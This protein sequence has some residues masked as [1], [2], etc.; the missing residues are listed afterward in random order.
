MSDSL[1]DLVTSRV[2][3][4]TDDQL[5]AIVLLMREAWRE[6]NASAF[7]EVSTALSTDYG[8][9]TMYLATEVEAKREETLSLARTLLDRAFERAMA[10]E[11]IAMS[12]EQAALKIGLSKRKLQDLVDQ[13]RLQVRRIDRR[14]LVTPDALREMLAD[15]D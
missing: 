15:S 4:L 1:R 12:L 5:D 9:P 8:P 6:G 13:G 11:P 10:V 3:G 14:V 7:D 2:A